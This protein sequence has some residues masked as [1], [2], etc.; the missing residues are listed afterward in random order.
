MLEL[1]S[2]TANKPKS[3]V[4]FCSGEFGDAI[5]S[6]GTLSTLTANADANSKIVLIKRE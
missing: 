2:L 1:F 6:L 5:I 4:L 3:M